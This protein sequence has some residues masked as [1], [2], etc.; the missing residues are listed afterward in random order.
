MS[1]TWLSGLNTNTV[2]G[3]YAFDTPD[4]ARAFAVE[5][6]PTEAAGFNA[7]F[8]TRIFDAAPVVQASREMNSPF[9]G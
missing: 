2:G 3:I 6:F 1:K 4:N 9:F 7:A 8:Y 5:Y